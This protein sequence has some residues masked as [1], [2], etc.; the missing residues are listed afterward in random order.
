MNDSKTKVE[1]ADFS[2]CIIIA[3]LPRSGTTALQ[4]LVASN[5]TVH[6][7]EE[8]WILPL[9]NNLLPGGHCVSLANNRTGAARA[10]FT[11]EELSLIAQR[12]LLEEAQAN[13]KSIFVEKT[14]RNYLVNYWGFIE[15]KKLLLVRDPRDILLSFIETFFEGT[16]KNLHGYQVDLNVGPDACV[17]LHNKFDFF[18]IKYED[19]L[20]RKKLTLLEQHINLRI[21]PENLKILPGEIGDRDK[22]KTLRERKPR[23]TRGLVKKVWINAQLKRNFRRYCD[24]FGY[25]L[26]FEDIRLSDVM[27]LANIRDLFWLSVYVCRLSIVFLQTKL[28][29]RYKLAIHL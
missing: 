10:G 4:R 17:Q 23:Q 6:A 19:L 2:N 29:L 7:P 21:D 15:T 11:F 12:K 3:G 24:T 25:Q 26:R 13:E 28:I 14:P 22:S 9:L 1:C 5:P 8:T 18:T 16:F 20:V 27:A